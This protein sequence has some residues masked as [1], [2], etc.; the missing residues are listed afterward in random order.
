M[1][2]LKLFLRKEF[3]KQLKICPEFLENLDNEIFVMTMP[4]TV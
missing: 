1:I 3:N 4:I 2:T